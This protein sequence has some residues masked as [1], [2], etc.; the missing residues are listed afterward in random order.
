MNKSYLWTIVILLSMSIEVHASNFLEKAE[1]KTFIKDLVEQ[2]G[3][4]QKSL[5]KLFENVTYQ[6][7][8]H[9]FYNK[10]IKYIAVASKQKK[11]PKACRSKGAWD[12]YSC[13]ILSYRS[14]QKGKAYMFKHRKT[15]HKAYKKYGV[16]AE[17]ITAIIGIESYYG[18]NCGN[19]PVFDTLVTLAFKENRRAAFFKSELKAFLLMTR[20][21]KIDPRKVKGSY[22][23]AIGL[24]QFM[25]SN[26]QTIAV[27]FDKNG[28]INLNHHADAIGSIANYLK[29]AGWKRGQE[30]AIP[31]SFLGNRYNAKKTGYQYKYKRTELKGLR[32]KRF[33]RYR[34]D[35]YLIKLKRDKHDELWF[36]TQ[37]FYAIT[38]YNHSDYYAMA[39]YQLAQKIMGRNVSQ[40]NRKKNIYDDTIIEY[41]E[42]N[43]FLD[44]PMK[45]RRFIIDL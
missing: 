30:V 39:V 18:Q 3:F 43:N 22:A 45:K 10:S 21:Q 34:G 28:A 17:Y 26:C 32:T 8:A 13:N 37:N 16:P 33:T 40:P 1:V 44:S 35:L 20:K 2:H 5:N 6:Q 36:G 4:N 15:L 14:V 19:Y 27:D 24:G 12:R 31:V 23:G 11:S 29:R 25:P 41:N 38:R 7:N 9:S 42:L